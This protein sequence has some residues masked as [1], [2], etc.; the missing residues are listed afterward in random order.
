MLKKNIIIKK[1]HY[2]F[3]FISKILSRKGIADF[4]RREFARI[5]FNAAVA[6]VGAGGKVEDLLR[7]YADKSGFTVTSLDIDPGRS[8]DILCDITC[9]HLSKSSFDVI[10]MAEVLEHVSNPQAAINGLDYLLK[11][12]GTIILTVPFIFPIHDRP[13]DYY[14]YTRY[15]LEYLFRDMADVKVVERNNWSEA[16]GVLIARLIMEKS[17]SARITAPFAVVFALLMLPAAILLGALIKTNF[18]TTGYLLTCK[19]H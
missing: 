11:P 16:I 19:K 10:V 4:L 13:Y 5:P 9:P 7:S 1:V 3:L 12:G 6:N 17:I 8:P 2:L 14:R 18:I 15:G